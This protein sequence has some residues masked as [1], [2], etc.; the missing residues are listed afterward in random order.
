MND[1][2][3]LALFQQIFKNTEAGKLGWQATA[4][5]NKFVA[6]MLGKYTLT[7]RP[8]PQW[9]EP[10]PPTVLVDD[11]K[12]NTIVEISNNVD[13][14]R[15]QDLHA[16]AVFAKR[17]A[18]QANEKIDELLEELKKDESDIPF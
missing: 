2:K 1:P 9:G 8:P 10:V 7:L 18:L 12:G 17:I 16:L 15:D 14:V 6:T 11:E 4:E 3:A 5:E 13:G